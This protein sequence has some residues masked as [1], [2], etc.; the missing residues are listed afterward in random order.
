[1]TL[2]SPT[3]KL[4]TF[5]ERRLEAALQEAHSADLSTTTVEALADN[6]IEQYRVEP[7]EVHRDGL[8]QLAASNDTVVMGHRAFPVRYRLPCSGTR[9]LWSK[10]PSHSYMNPAFLNTTKMGGDDHLIITMQLPALN[11]ATDIYGD[12]ERLHVLQA[13]QQKSVQDARDSHIKQLQETV[14]RSG[15]QTNPWNDSLAIQ[16]RRILE[17]RAMVAVEAMRFAANSDVPVFRVEEAEQVPLQPGIVRRKLRPDASSSEATLTAEIYEDIVQTIE[18]MTRAMERT[19]TAARLGE[20]E[21][22]DLIL[23]VLNANYR[24]AAAGEVFNGTGKTDILL[25]WNDQNA[26]IG[27]CKFWEGPARFRNAIDQLHG[28]VTW[29]DTK[30]ALILFVKA[31]KPTD[32]IDKASHELRKH[33]TFIEEAP[34]T[35]G[36]R[37]DFV[38][39]AA[40]DDAKHIDVALVVV[41][42]PT[43]QE[44]AAK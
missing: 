38:M 27:E 37:R 43:R 16:I 44:T 40:D 31:G 36:T 1:M 26:F 5:L 21:I 29:R 28:Y 24:G 42:L 19:P 2:F 10:E 12:T 22:R 4:S 41:I 20:E 15:D 30:A 34:R 14:K 6:I 18:Q 39:C 13:E 9:E 7:L 11:L 32:I 17:E 8:T 3:Q 33:R 25:R 35:N 23:F